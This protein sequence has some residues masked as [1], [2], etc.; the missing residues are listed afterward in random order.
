[1]YLLLTDYHRFTYKNAYPLPKIKKVVHKVCK[2]KV[3]S[4]LD[5]KSAHHQIP[6]LE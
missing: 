6:M 3:L 2:Y 1:M 4:A 5:L